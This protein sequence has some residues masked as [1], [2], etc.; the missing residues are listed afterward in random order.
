[1]N[2]APAP[3]VYWCGPAIDPDRVYLVRTAGDPAN[4]ENAVRKTMQAVEPARAVY[5]LAPLETQLSDAF[6]EERLRTLLLTLFAGTA[7]AL[8]C[9]GLYGTMTYF[10]TTKRR[11]IGVRMALGARRSQVGI[12]FVNQGM[13]AAGAGIAAGFAMA[14]WA[15]RFVASML[16]GVKPND[17]A[18]FAAAIL[19][20]LSVALT[21]SAIPAIRAVRAMPMRVLREE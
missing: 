2:E 5:D 1:M 18:A 16:Y 14:L 3:T 19:T 7:L 4:L 15:A 13:A 6:G 11:E 8:A 9:V 20:M 10:V 17:A 12:R 21:A